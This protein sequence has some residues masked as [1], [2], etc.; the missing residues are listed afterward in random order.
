MKIALLLIGLFVLAACTETQPVEEPT[1]ESTFCTDPRPEICT[2]VYD[3][4]CGSDGK[5][6][7]NACVACSNLEVRYSVQGECK[8]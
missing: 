5:T 3:P 8:S 1:D 2:A 7:S 6:Y 4:V